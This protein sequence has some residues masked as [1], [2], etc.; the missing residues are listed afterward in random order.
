[1]DA[2]TGRVERVNYRHAGAR[3]LPRDVLVPAIL[4]AF[5]TPVAIVAALILVG[6]LSSGGVN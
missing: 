4:L 2:T 6:A 5:L 1:M 3:P